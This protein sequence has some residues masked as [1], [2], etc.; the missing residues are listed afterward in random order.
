MEKEAKR[1]LVLISIFAIAM[2]FVEA[3][4]VYYL[5]KLYYSGVGL[6]PLNSMIPAEVLKLEWIREFFTVI[7]LLS[8]AF[9]VG[10]KLKDK[11]AYFIYTFAVWDIFYYVWLKFTLSW[12]VHLM[13]WDILF[14]IPITWASPCI[15]PVIISAMLIILALVILKF[16]KENI[17]LKEWILLLTAGI[18]FFITFIWDYAMILFTNKLSQQELMQALS[19][20][21]PIEYNWWL[22]LIGMLLAGLAMLSFIKRAKRRK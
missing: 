7:M 11:F 4:V 14:L 3:M 1:N 19:T 15:A 16:P 8:I 12:P 20:H 5:R 13:D 22:F 17:K 9:L 2:A 6:F 21:V 10:K 18:V